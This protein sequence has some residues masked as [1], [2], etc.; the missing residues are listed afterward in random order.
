M[1][2]VFVLD[3]QKQPL[4]PV[5]PGRA[6]WLLKNRLCPIAAISMEFARFD[7]QALQHPHIEGCQYQQGTLAGYE[8]REYLL[9]KWRRTCAYCGA[10]DVPLEV[11]HIIPKAR[12][13]TDRV[14]NLTLA[15]VPCNQSKGQQTAAEFAYPEVQAQ[16]RTPLTDTAAVNTTRWALY[17]QLQATGLPVET[18]SGGRTKYNCARQGLPKTH[19][20]DAACVGAS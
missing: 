3:T 14:S 19:W 12:G 2:H 11:E 7:P 10:T 5:H 16:A 8:V 18:G 17:Q 13:G 15:C 1:S 6:R 4:R 9:E 20:L